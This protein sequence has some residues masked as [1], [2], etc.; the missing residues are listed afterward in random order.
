MTTTSTS[1]TETVFL[2][3]RCGRCW[4]SN[5]AETTEVGQTV[6]C[7]VCGSNNVVPEATTDRIER[8]EALISESMHELAP[9][10]DQ[11]NAA[12]NKKRQDFYR[13]PTDKELAAKAQAASYVPLH[14]RDFRGY[15]NASTMARIA[16]F[17]GDSL[18]SIT[19]LFFGFVICMWMSKQGWIENPLKQFQSR[20]ELNWQLDLMVCMPF[21]MLQIVQWGLLATRG[22]SIGK[23]ILGIRIVGISGQVSGFLQTVLVRSWICNLLSCII[24]FFTL[25]NCVLIFSNSKRCLHDYISGTRVVSS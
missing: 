1:T 5:C 8:A 23:F 3:Y 24:P 16:A 22:Q 19:S 11:A 10:L 20:N 13:V 15:P 14:K 18:L 7:R 4:N 2:E 21:W 9:A 12:S 25:V 17:I 6:P